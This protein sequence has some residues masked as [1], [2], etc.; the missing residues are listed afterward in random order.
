MYKRQPYDS[1]V[2]DGAEPFSIAQ[3]P[4]VRDRVFVLNSFSCLLYTSHTQRTGNPDGV[5]GVE[6]GFLLRQGALHGGGQVLLQTLGT[7]YLPNKSLCVPV[8]A[9][10]STRTSSSMR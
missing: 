7:V 3:V 10:V 8:R 5:D 2:Y 4:E 1:I 6:P 9:S